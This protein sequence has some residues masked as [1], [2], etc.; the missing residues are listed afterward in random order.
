MTEEKREKPSE[1]ILR[2][3]LEIAREH[4]PHPGLPPYSIA[5]GKIAAIG[6]ILDEIVESNE[7]MNV[8]DPEVPRVAVSTLAAR[9]AVEF[10]I[11]N[12]GLIAT[13][14]CA[15]GHHKI[16]DALVL[17]IDGLVLDGLRGGS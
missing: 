17:V 12:G 8:Q 15:C 11:D 6:E 1:R 3:G 2:R 5:E 9:R 10:L 14:C 7:T 16:A 4:Y 13:I